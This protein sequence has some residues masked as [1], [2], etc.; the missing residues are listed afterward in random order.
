MKVLWVV[1]TLFPDLSKKLNGKLPTAG[2]WM[3]GL[4]NDL[5]AHGISLTVVTSRPKVK[6]YQGIINN[7]NYYLLS[8]SKDRAKYDS[9]L[10]PQWKK[11][12]EEINPDVVHIHGTEYAQG[13]AL[14]KVCPE[15]KFVIS[16]QGLISV[17]SRYYYA[18]IAKEDLM[19]HITIRDFFKRDS[20]IRAQ[21]KFEQ[22][23]RDVELAYLRNAKDVIGRTQWDF[24]HTKTIN[25]N[26]TY[27]FCNESL[28]DPFYSSVKWNKNTKTDHTLFLSQAGYPLKGLHKV[29]EAVSIVKRK[30]P[31]IHIKVAGSNIINKTTLKERLR[32]GGYQSYLNSL[33]KQHG[34]K[35]HITFTGPLSSEQMIQEYLNCHIFI[36]PSSIENSPNS[37]GEAQLLGVPC[38]AS[39]VGGVPDMVVDGETGL[40]YRFEEVEMLAQAIIKIFDNPD[41]AQK[42]SSNAIQVATI[43]HERQTNVNRLLDIYNIIRK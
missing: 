14:I 30:F 39:Y 4:A 6:K 42:L 40:L 22:K 12:V 27:H 9:S 29:I 3:Y 1:N 32:L 11:I 25:P 19:K 17:Y 15:L 43:R 36:C 33:L 26:S 34:L 16:I 31:D 21:L 41:M 10:E 23:G 5:V 38:I 13:L 20:V 2:G 7:I 18:G 35:D 28:R 24:D 8:G 37:L